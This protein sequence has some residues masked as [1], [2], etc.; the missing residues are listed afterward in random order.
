MSDSIAPPRCAAGEPGV[1]HHDVDAAERVHRARHRLR[2]A[3][4]RGDVAVVGH[5]LATAGA[6]LR[7]DGVGDRLVAARPSSSAPTS[8]TTTLAP[9]WREQQ[10]VRTT[11]AASS[12]GHDGDPAL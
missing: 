11:D 4:E 12:P 2:R 1:V 9:R 10:G 5:R 6:D 3:F 8:H 7:N